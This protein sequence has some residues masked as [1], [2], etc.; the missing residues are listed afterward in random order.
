MRPE[1]LT[2]TE[3]EAMGDEEV[4]IWHSVME[5]QTQ[6]AKIRKAMLDFIEVRDAQKGPRIH[7]DSEVV[8]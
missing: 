4:L 8:D 2:K 6:V 5:R 7:V 1:D 3:V